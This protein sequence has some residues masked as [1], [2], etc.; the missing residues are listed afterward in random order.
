MA[1]STT[2]PKPPRNF[3]HAE[4]N[5]LL[6]VYRQSGLQRGSNHI[7][8][9]SWDRVAREMIY[10]ARLAP[11]WD[12]RRAYT[13]ENF[14]FNV[15]Q[16]QAY[17]PSC[18]CKSIVIPHHFSSTHFFPN[19][20]AAN[21]RSK[22]MSSSSPTKSGQSAQSSWKVGIDVP[23]P[24]HWT[25][26][27]KENLKST[28]TSLGYSSTGGFPDIVKWSKVAEKMNDEARANSSW[29]VGR[30]YGWENCWNAAKSG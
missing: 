1:N 24:N 30:R 22:A 3:T 25:A 29:D 20:P 12:V 18:P 28:Y 13:E 16:T 6:I 19:N 2:A 14:L 27:E 8:R 7:F 10:R 11:E 17:D 5:A 23:P 15:S 26:K 21:S 9:G 4:K